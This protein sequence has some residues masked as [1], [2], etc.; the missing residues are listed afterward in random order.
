MLIGNDFLEIANGGRTE[1]VRS[2]AKGRME[3]YRLV[4]KQLD[5]RFVELLSPVVQL[6]CV[7]FSWGF[8]W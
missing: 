4:A 6:S 5:T 2:G 8:S 3:A 1:A 7:R